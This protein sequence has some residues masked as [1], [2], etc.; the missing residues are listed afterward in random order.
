MIFNIILPVSG[1]FT[2]KTWIKG[3][4][5]YI[6]G[7]EVADKEK[8]HLLYIDYDGKQPLYIDSQEVITGIIQEKD[9]PP[10]VA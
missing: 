8:H 4:K 5:I 2:T 6:D 10:P 7:V 9:A 3:A 1:A